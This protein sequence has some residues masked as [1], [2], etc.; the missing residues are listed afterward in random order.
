[1]KKIILFH[2]IL[3]ICWQC[4]AS[5]P[6]KGIPDT[7]T[8]ERKLD[9]TV[10]GQKRNY[11]VHIPVNYDPGKR[12]PLVLILH[13]AF[14][15]GRQIERQSGFSKLSDREGFLAVYPNGSFGLFGF[16]QH[17]NAGHCCGKAQADNIDDVGFLVQ[18]IRDISSKLN[19]D[20]TRIYMVGFSNGGMLVYRFAAEQTNLLAA[21]APMAASLGGRASSHDSLWITPH[22]KGKLPLI[23]FH[24]EDDPNVP[25]LGGISPKKGGEREYLSVME[26]IDFWITNNGCSKKFTEEQLYGNKVIHKVWPDSAGENDIELYLLKEWG[27]KWPGGKFTKKLNKSNPLHQFDAAEIIW[28]FFKKHHK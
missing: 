20:S 7:G 11:L 22:P 17:W 21:A 9:I 26:S 23:I 14:G 24:S 16:F 6:P 13:G 3:L 18:V 25:Y 15:T 2:F 12:V 8:Y 27:H 19:V 28:E 5:F 10:A 4:T 1:M